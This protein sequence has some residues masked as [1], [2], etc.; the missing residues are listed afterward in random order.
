MRKNMIA[1][2][3][4]LALG[5]ATMSTAAVAAQRGGTS[6]GGGGGHIGGGAPGGH[7]VMGGG[8]GTFG[9]GGMH[10]NFGANMGR[11]NMG[12]PS[13]G[14]SFVNTAPGNFAG[15]R[16]NFAGTRGTFAGRDFDRDRDHDR[17]FRGFGFGGLYAYDP[18]YYDYSDADTYYGDGCWQRQ[19]VPT[20]FGLRWQLVDVCA[21]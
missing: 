19:L 17:R 12:R 8:A 20:P 18:G 10:G 13:G 7:A 3:A 1:L 14:G 11:P 21:Y 6:G 2:A 15:H 9:G 5:T 4:A 16:N